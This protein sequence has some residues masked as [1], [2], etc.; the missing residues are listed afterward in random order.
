MELTERFE[1]ATTCAFTG[2][3][4]RALPWGMMRAIHAVWRQKNAWTKHWSGPTARATAISF[5]AWPRG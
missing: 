2:H 1:R 5:A 3:R 4:P